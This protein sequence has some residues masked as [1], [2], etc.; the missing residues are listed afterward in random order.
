M[1]RRP[2]K[3]N[4]NKVKHNICEMIKMSCWSLVVASD[5]ERSGWSQVGDILRIYL[6]LSCMQNINNL[7]R[8]EKL[9]LGTVCLYP[10]TAQKSF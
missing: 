2:I 9:I 7:G 1:S 8:S 3:L 5:S 4:F 6:I 10:Y